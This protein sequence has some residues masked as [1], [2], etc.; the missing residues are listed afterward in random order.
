MSTET[1]QLPL[2]AD[3]GR[4]TF[5]DLHTGRTVQAADIYE[6]ARLLYSEASLPSYVKPGTDDTTRLPIWCCGVIAGNEYVG[7]MFW[8]R[9][10]E[11]YR[12]A[13]Y[14]HRARQREARA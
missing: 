4:D 10:E 12:A 7:M 14:A 9:D 3:P 2:F 6:A 13:I 5:T 1:S 8:N 11:A